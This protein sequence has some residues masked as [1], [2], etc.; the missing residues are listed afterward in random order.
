MPRK[1]WHS[2]GDSASKLCNEPGECNFC[3]SSPMLSWAL[4]LPLSPHSSKSLLYTCWFTRPDLVELFRGPLLVSYPGWTDISSHLPSSEESF[5]LMSCLGLGSRDKPTVW[6]RLKQHILESCCSDCSGLQ[7]GKG[8]Q[9]V[10]FLVPAASEVES[11]SLCL[12]FVTPLFPCMRA[13]FN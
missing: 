5:D 2:V 7:Q 3:E 1:Q 12:S 8:L 13:P 6:T 10:C 9:R 11:I 4:G